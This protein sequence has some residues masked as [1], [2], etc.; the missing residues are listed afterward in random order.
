M[1]PSAR[2]R[3]QGVLVTPLLRSAP[4]STRVPQQPAKVNKLQLQH[5]EFYVYVYTNGSYMQIELRR[6]G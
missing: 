4:G 3:S 5:E 1:Q 6:T 2:Q